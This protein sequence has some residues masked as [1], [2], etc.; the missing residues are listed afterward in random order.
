[1]DASPSE[2]TMKLIIVLIVL[3]V[4]ALKTIEKDGDWFDF[5]QMDAQYENAWTNFEFNMVLGVL[6]F[7]GIAGLIWLYAIA[8]APNLQRVPPAIVATQRSAPVKKHHVQTQ[9]AKH[10]VQTQPAK[11]RVQTQPAKKH[12]N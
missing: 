8:M 11:H 10:R 1:M 5:L 12:P 2:D 7:A 3:A 9:P 4:I 6:S